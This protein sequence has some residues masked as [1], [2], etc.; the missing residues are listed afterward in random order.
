MKNPV[1]LLLALALFLGALAV[2]PVA[3]GRLVGDVN[4][5]GSLNAKDVTTIMKVLVGK[6]VKS[7]DAALADVNGDG[8]VNAKDVTKLMK[9]IVRG[10]SFGALPDDA[11][12][13]DPGSSDDPDAP[14]PYEPPVDDGVIVQTR[15]A[16]TLIENLTYNG[17]KQGVSS[18]WIVDN[19]GGVPKTS[20][21]DNNA[22]LH[23]ISDK[24]GTALIHEFNKIT[25]GRITLET[26]AIVNGS[27]FSLE[28]TNENGEAIYRL[29]SADDGWRVALSGGDSTLLL[30]GAA[31]GE[32]YT[33]YVTVDLDECT[34]T[35]IVNDVD[36]GSH[37]LIKSGDEANVLDFRFATDGPGTASARLG[38]IR[39]Y[40]NYALNDEFHL[41]TAGDL[42]RTWG[43]VPT[44]ANGEISFPGGA[45]DRAFSP[46][47]GTAI[48]ETQFILP[49]GE[50]FSFD[51]KGGGNTVLT[52][53]SRDGK[54]YVGSAKVY[55]DFV[56]NL[57]YR[58]RFEIDSAAKKAKVRLNGR[59]IYECAVTVPESG[60]DAITVTNLSGTPIKFDCF[61]AFEK[62]SHDDYV[63]EPV[64]PAG[65]D[66]HIVGLNVCSLWRDGTLMGWSTV[67]P[68]P[69]NMPVL[70]YYDEGIPE[71]ADWEIKYLV[72]HGV[73]FQAFCWYA[74]SRNQPLNT[75]NLSY[76][77][78][79]HLH[80][81]YMNAEYSDMMKYCI[82]WECA[83]GECPRN[84]QDFL[85]YYLPYFIENY[86]KDDRYMVI[87]NKPVVMMF[88]V[89]SFVQK[90]GGEG[91]AQNIIDDIDMALEE[92]GYDG[93]LMIAS[94][95]ASNDYASIG[96]DGCAAY[97]W[98][99]SGASFKKTKE[100]I[101][102]SAA[103]TRLYTIPTASV[104]F[105]D[106][107]WSGVRSPMITVDEY[108][109]LNEWISKQYVP[110][111]AKQD[112]QKNLSFLS[113]WNEYGE[114]TYIM[115]CMD[116]VGF[117]YL[118]VLRE[119][120][121]DEKADPR[122]NVVPTANQKDRICKMYPQYRHLLRKQGNID[123]TDE[124]V[125]SVYVNGYRL[126]AKLPY[127]GY[128]A[129]MELPYEK[130]PTGELLIPFDP[131][132][133]LDLTLNC[134]HKWD[135]A[136]KTLSLEFSDH[137]LVFT[138][139]KDTYIL[140]GKEKSLGFTLTDQDGLPMLPIERLC[141]DVGYTCKIINGEAHITTSQYDYYSANI[142]NRKPGCWEFNVEGSSEGWTST[143][144]D[145]DVRGGSLFA[146]SREDSWSQIM[147]NKSDINL[148]ASDYAAFEIRCKY[149]YDVGGQQL[150]RL[151]F[152]TNVD[153]VEK[154]DMK[155]QFL[156]EEA[157]KGEWITLR[158]DLTPG[159]DNG[160][161]K[162]L[163]WNV[164]DTIKSLRLDPFNTFG[165]I[166]IDYMRFLKADEIG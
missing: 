165:E 21:F 134:F 135:L 36:F 122:L 85:D 91:I 130:S 23:D 53:S 27:G 51:I 4:G 41:C 107:A 129:G 141:A 152:T 140:D 20:I 2:A 11:P 14:A 78:L 54:F 62:L 161:H 86:F 126:G 131:F 39:M 3:S 160:K 125:G 163:G 158:M 106:I 79:S 60:V 35:T 101:Y 30:K 10:E 71:T 48:V 149:N 34:S 1:S 16:Y 5:D 150:M 18:G 155:I 47:T 84:E 148:K 12:A 63:P 114:G 120:Y 123:T 28:Y 58:L 44:V 117:G 24:D 49:C 116:H 52:F 115:P 108:R 81:G 128:K 124:D 9:A 137:T 74:P 93:A 64:I 77:T 8:G 40:A 26:S 15:D 65:E 145:L 80:D 109:Q 7:Y 164:E 110:Y 104:G 31:T 75:T 46:V 43:A 113:T 118:D 156:L 42:L 50:N 72:E 144:M 33:F 56:A 90:V 70:G 119:V 111:R 151:Y 95:F 66:K 136:S 166:E 57:W 132:I 121:T 103:E 92:M 139:G 25:V 37:P 143:Q 100:L 142:S 97:N 32:T 69:E 146:S 96:I 153:A 6:S 89:E 17:V 61:R 159:A 87:D 154:E 55:D 38:A 138:V 68:Y 112:W 147:W 82:I 88:G 162:V 133:A 76:K 102:A 13:A 59:V 45:F 73:D 83:N 22:A 99:E 29:F 105:N 127:A 98:R 19:R 157:D 94:S 67:T